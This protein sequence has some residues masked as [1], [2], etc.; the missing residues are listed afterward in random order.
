MIPLFDRNEQHAVTSSGKTVRNRGMNPSDDGLERA[1]G[2]FRRHVR[3]ATFFERADAFIVLSDNKK[4]VLLSD[5]LEKNIIRDIVEQSILC[6]L[7]VSS[8]LNGGMN[9]HESKSPALH[10]IRY[11]DCHRIPVAAGSDLS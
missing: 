1:R 3:R 7:H 11:P 9:Y 6:N 4:S 2:I 10:H 8:C 5:G